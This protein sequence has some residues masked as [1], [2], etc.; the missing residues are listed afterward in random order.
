VHV[1]YA[2]PG[3]ALAKQKQ[4]AEA[5]NSPLILGPEHSLAKQAYQHQQ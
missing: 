4:A 3:S 1:L 2:T 5:T